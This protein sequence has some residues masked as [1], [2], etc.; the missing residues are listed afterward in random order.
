MLQVQKVEYKVCLLLQVCRIMKCFNPT[1]RCGDIELERVL[2][3]RCK[4]CHCSIIY[5]IEKIICMKDEMCDAMQQRWHDE[6]I[7]RDRQNT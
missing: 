3:I 1:C 5:D 7:N 2:K 4:N 6:I